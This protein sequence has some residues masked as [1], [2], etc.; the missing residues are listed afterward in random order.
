LIMDCLC[1]ILNLGA[2]RETVAVKPFSEGVMRM[3]TADTIAFTALIF[4]IVF[5]TYTITK[6]K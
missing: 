6:K 5:V 3:S 4:Y 2:T 1:D